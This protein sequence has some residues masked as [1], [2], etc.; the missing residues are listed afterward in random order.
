MYQRSNGRRSSIC[1]ERCACL[2]WRQA[3]TYSD[4]V[5][6]EEVTANRGLGPYVTGYEA[7]RSRATLRREGDVGRSP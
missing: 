3:M 5:F 7:R 4:V 2:C 6:R 1:E